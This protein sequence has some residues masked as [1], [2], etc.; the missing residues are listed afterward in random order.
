M[1][2][3]RNVFLV[4]L[5]YV[6][7]SL[8][9]DVFQCPAES[10]IF[11]CECY[12]QSNGVNIYCSG[13]ELNIINDVLAGFTQPIQLLMISQG[14]YTT[15]PERALFNIVDARAI[16]FYDCG[17]EEVNNNAFSNIPYLQRLE[18]VGNKLKQVFFHVFYFKW[19]ASYCIQMCIATTVSQ[20]E[21]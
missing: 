14:N 4:F 6:E 10:E 2:A 19:N 3:F 21:E 12:P 13:T 9:Q 16:A 11:P 7:R 20:D 8:A 5:L 15:L 18:F 17:I 1:A